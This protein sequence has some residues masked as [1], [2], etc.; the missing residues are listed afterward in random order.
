MF[1]SSFN[2]AFTFCFMTRGKCRI[3]SAQFEYISQFLFWSSSCMVFSAALC[4]MLPPSTS[5]RFT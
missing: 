4:W 3:E 2:D 5:I 1:K